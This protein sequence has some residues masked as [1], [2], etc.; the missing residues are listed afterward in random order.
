MSKRNMGEKK[1][2]DKALDE[3]QNNGKEA[4]LT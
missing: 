1:G 2:G 4:V 3:W